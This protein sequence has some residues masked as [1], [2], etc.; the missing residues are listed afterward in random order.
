[1]GYNAMEG[2]WDCS[3][4]EREANAMERGTTGSYIIIKT[5]ETGPMQEGA[6]SNQH[7]WYSHGRT[8]F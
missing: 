2:T 1:M 7:S 6:H 3:A 4:R 5:Q 8:T